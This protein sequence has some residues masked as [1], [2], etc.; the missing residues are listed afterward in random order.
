[1]S[2]RKLQIE[3]KQLRRLIKQLEKQINN[4]ICE[5]HVRIPFDEISDEVQRLKSIWEETEEQKKQMEQ[6]LLST[7]NGTS[8]TN[9]SSSMTFQSAEIVEL[10]LQK[11]YV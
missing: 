10:S 2:R 5:T 6:K 8:K 4:K 9:P 1:M 11:Q 7:E 3:I